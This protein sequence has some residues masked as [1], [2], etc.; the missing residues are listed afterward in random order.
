MFYA[1]KMRRI[2]LVL[3]ISLLIFSFM[4][5]AEDWTSLGEPSPDPLLGLF[6]VNEYLGWAVGGSFIGFPRHP[7]S[8]ILKTTDGGAIWETQDAPTDAQLYGVTFYNTTLGWVVGDGVILNTVDGGDNWI[9][10]LI[11]SEVV[12]KD[13]AYYNSTTLFAVGW[14]GRILKTTT[15]GFPWVEQSSGTVALL[16]G[17]AVV[18]NRIAYVVGDG[19]LVLKTTDGGSRWERQE[20]LRSS[21]NIPLAL[22]DIQC[23]DSERC[24]I[25]ASNDYICTTTDGGS[26]W[27]CSRTGGIIG[28][29]TISYIDFDIGWATGGAGGDLRF[30]NDGG[31]TWDVQTADEP[32]PF[33]LRSLQMMEA[34]CTDAGYI[35]YVVGDATSGPAGVFRY[36]E[37]PPVSW[38][39]APSCENGTLNTLRDEYSCITGYECVGEPYYEV[40]FPDQNLT[41]QIPET[42]CTPILIDCGSGESP[43]YEY[44]DDGCPESYTCVEVEESCQENLAE[45]LGPTASDV[46]REDCGRYTSTQDCITCY[47]QYDGCLQGEGDGGPRCSDSD[48]GNNIYE[49]GLLEAYT[50]RWGAQFVQEYCVDEEGSRQNSSS[51]VEELVCLEGDETYAYSHVRTPCPEGY[52]CAGGACVYTSFVLAPDQQLSFSQFIGQV[53]GLSENEVI[54]VALLRNDGSTSVASFQIEQKRLLEVSA[55]ERPDWTLRAEVREET[56]HRIVAAE[57]PVAEALGAIDSKEIKLKG[58]TAGKKMKLALLKIGLKLAGVFRSS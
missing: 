6:F 16:E 31:E 41:V 19:G 24:R 37:L 18:N 2:F 45:C 5:Y 3:F 7:T 57:D 56:L 32:F 46:S 44:A 20:E 29:S 21:F 53:P 9:E 22:N 17:I 52:I 8:M 25:A 35:G 23:V 50:P 10:Q 15:G 14:N 26:D 58:R 54:V 47:D 38:P 36:G 1:F 48:G 34:A 4:S 43:D 13:I 27:N 51:L 40:I 39:E 42:E 30:T 33:F 49:Q 11:P 55:R 28:F 12:Y